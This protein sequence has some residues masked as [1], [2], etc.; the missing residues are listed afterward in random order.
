MSQKTT[1]EISLSEMTADELKKFD[2]LMQTTA[3]VFHHQI[4]FHQVIGFSFDELTAHQCKISFI[5]K[6]ELIGNRHPSAAPHG[7]Y[8]CQGDDRW[9]AIACFNDEEWQSLCRAMAPSS[10]EQLDQER[11]ATQTGRKS[12]EDDLDRIIAQWTINWESAELMTTLQ[13]VGV[14][15]GKVNDC[16]DLYE[17]PQLMHRKHFQYLEHPE[18]G[19]YASDTSEWDLSQSPGILHRAAPMIGQDTEYVLRE[20]IGLTEDEYQSLSQDGLFV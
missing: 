19:R 9:I 13:S 3:D 6:P 2:Q 15:A 4:P 18:M 10:P 17:D 14:P 7:V 20:F 11:F 1:S 8:P 5:K 12:D 16:R